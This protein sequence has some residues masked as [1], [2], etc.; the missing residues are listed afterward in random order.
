MTI[1]KTT[2]SAKPPIAPPMQRTIYAEPI[3]Q[4]LDDVLWRASICVNR[5]EKEEWLAV[6]RQVERAADPALWW[7]SL[8]ISFVSGAGIGVAA[9]LFSLGH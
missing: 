2:P 6:A 3:R 5:D 7:A 1:R 4:V 9:I 8:A